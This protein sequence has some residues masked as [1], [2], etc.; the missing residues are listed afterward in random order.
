ME[1]DEL[2][3]RLVTVEQTLSILDTGLEG[4]LY[5]LPSRISSAGEDILAT[6]RGDNH[7]YGRWVEHCPG[8]VITVAIFSI[9]ALIALGRVVRILGA[10]QSGRRARTRN[11][12]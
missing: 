8:R 1:S 7:D 5:Q 12:T 11:D 4:A 9:V 3:A 2:G 10:T 6:I